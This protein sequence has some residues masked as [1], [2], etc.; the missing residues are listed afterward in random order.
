[1]YNRR[2]Y[3]LTKNTKQLEIFQYPSKFLPSE[4]GQK[5]YSKVR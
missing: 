4:V 1:M 2:G 5:E 3:V